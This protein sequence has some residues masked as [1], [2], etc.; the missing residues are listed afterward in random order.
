MKAAAAAARNLNFMSFSHVSQRT[1][2]VSLGGGDCPVTIKLQEAQVF[3]N[4]FSCAVRRRL[5]RI[6]AISA[7]L[8][9][10]A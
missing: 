10:F 5:P 1:K 8:A 2:P 9:Q 6:R 7:L 3:A 4:Q